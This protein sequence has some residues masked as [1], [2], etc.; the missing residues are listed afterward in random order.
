M[1]FVKG[2]RKLFFSPYCVQWTFLR[3]PVCY[4]CTTDEK[5]RLAQTARP[6]RILSVSD[7]LRNK[8]LTSSTHRS[9]R[10]S[11]FLGYRPLT[12][13]IV[14]H[15]VGFVK[16]FYQLF[17]RASSVG[18]EP[19]GS[20]PSLQPRWDSPLDCLYCTTNLAVC[21]YLFWNSLNFF[22][23]RE[24]ALLRP[25]AAGFCS[26]S[27]C[28]PRHLWSTICIAEKWDALNPFGVKSGDFTGL[29]RIFAVYCRPTCGEWPLF[30][31]L[32]RGV[33]LTVSLLYHI[34]SGLSRPFSNFFQ[35]FFILTLSVRLATL[36]WD[37]Y[38]IAN[39]CPNCN[40]QN[41][42]IT[43]F[44]HL[45]LCA[46]YIL[47]KLLAAWYNGNSA[48]DAR[49][50]AANYSTLFALCQAWIFI[51]FQC[52]IIHFVQKNEKIPSFLGIFVHFTQDFGFRFCTSVSS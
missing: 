21:Q 23:G 41:T 49:P 20:G 13:L 5:H 27:L 14:P 38:S 4:S 8:W 12:V 29:T 9:T 35:V 16:G 39:G 22:W 48:Q 42:Q 15:F 32:V 11:A 6:L 25:S 33:P 45:H 17:F 31:P 7:L 44:L 51:H 19:L 52:K 26:K 3:H 24:L 10:P 1:P 18:F 37:N 46:L 36:P 43:G 47:T 30:T 34:G 28:H 40:R 2:F 50:R